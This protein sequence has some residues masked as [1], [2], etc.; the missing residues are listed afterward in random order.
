MG[1]PPGPVTVTA[2]TVPEGKPVIGDRK[3]AAVGAGVVGPPVS[4]PPPHAES[5]G[6][7][8]R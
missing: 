6:D 3:T 5:S 7:Q 1:I 4:P 2:A 8:D